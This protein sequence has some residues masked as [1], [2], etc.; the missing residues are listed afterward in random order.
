MNI[1][2]SILVGVILFVSG[3]GAV[4]YIGKRSLEIENHNKDMA[5]MAYE[6]MIKNV[7]FEALATERKEV[8]NEKIIDIVSDISI[9]SDGSYSGV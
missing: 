7:P 2:T 9:I 1:L 6:A 3:F 8:S 4:Q 5:I